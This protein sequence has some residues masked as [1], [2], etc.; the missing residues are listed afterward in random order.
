MVVRPYNIPLITELPGRVAART[1]S[2][3]RPQVDGIILERLFEEGAEVRKGQPLYHIDPDMYRA[4]RD[5][6]KATL[7]EAQAKAELLARQENR[8]RHLARV[9]AV[10]QNDLDVATAERRQAKARVSHAR[11]ELERAELNL[12]HTTIKA[13]ASGRIGISEVS[14][15]SLVTANQEQ[16]LAFIQEIGSVYVDFTQPSTEIL[17]LRLRQGTRANGE[18]TSPPRITLKLENDIP[19]TSHGAT[20][21]EDREPICGK[22]LF[23]DISV[24]Q[25]TGNVTLRTVFDN[26]DGLLLP[27]M[28]VKGIIEEGREDVLLVPQKCVFSLGSGIHGIFVLQQQTDGAFLL[29]KRRVELETV[30]ENAWIVAR[31][32]QTGELVLTEGIQRAKA[33]EMVQGREINPFPGLHPVAQGSAE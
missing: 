7:E 23:T 21:E 25:D 26:P 18:G 11:A 2:E 9:N 1:L 19:Y 8:Q 31:G 3:V 6:A 15:G 24:E 17:R 30:Y 13:H 33:G 14:P 32:V 16:P 29:E 27:G 4:E 20:R 12:A 22:L 10:S 28:Y 5:A